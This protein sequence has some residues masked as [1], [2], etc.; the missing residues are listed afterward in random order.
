LKN[1]F[2]IKKHPLVKETFMER[3]QIVASIIKIANE[4]DEMGMYAEANQLTKVAQAAGS[5]FMQGL[6]DIGEGTA[7]G[8]KGLGRDI[9]KGFEATKQGFSDAGELMGGGASNLGFGIVNPA[10]EMGLGASEISSNM[11]ENRL[12]SLRETAM[13][14]PKSADSQARTLDNNIKLKI[15]NLQNMPGGGSQAGKDEITKLMQKR[16]EVRKFFIKDEP[17]SGAGLAYRGQA[18]QL[19][20]PKMVNDWIYNNSVGKNLTKGQLYDL[21]KQEKG[22]SFANT[23]SQQLSDKNITRRDQIVNPSR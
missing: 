19:Q 4:L 10:T 6:R 17:R 14:N 13:Q 21:A 23:M 1:F 11:I 3:R 8:I 16:V 22:D 2:I 5:Q 15:E 9:G 7:R 18:N 12:R 20:D